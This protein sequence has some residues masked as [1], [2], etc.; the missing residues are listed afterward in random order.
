MKCYFKPL[1]ELFGKFS[2]NLSQTV[3]ERKEKHGNLSGKLLQKKKSPECGKE[4]VQIIWTIEF[5]NWLIDLLTNLI[6]VLKNP[7]RNLKLTHF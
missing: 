6:I 7:E 5:F 3:N 4:K 2:N 1:I